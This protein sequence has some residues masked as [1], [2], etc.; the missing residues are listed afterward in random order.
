MT[1]SAPPQPQDKTG[2]G[3]AAPQSCK[4]FFIMFTLILLYYY[5]SF[6]YFYHLFLRGH[7]LNQRSACPEPDSALI[8]LICEQILSKDQEPIRF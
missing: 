3:L 1:V 8:S 6:Y 5:N 2:H 7:D 4:A